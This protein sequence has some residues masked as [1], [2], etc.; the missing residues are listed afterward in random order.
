MTRLAVYRSSLLACFAAIAFLPAFSQSVVVTPTTVSFGN[1]PQG[2]SS[3][4]HKVTLKNGQSSA[5]TIS[6]ISTSLSDYIASNNCPVSPAT[7][8]AGATC[9]ISITFT[10][11]VE[12]SRTAALTVVDTGLSSPQLVTLNGTGTAP[13][14]LSIAVTPATA[15]VAAGY[16]EQFTATGTYSNGTTANLTNTAIWSSSAT[17]VAT[18]IGTSGLATG[19]AQGKASITATV[20]TI[21]GSTRLT[22]TPAVLTSLSVTPITAPIIAGQTQQFTATGTYS[23]GTS[24]NLTS[25]AK[26]SSSSTSVATVKNTGASHRNRSGHSYHHS[27]GR[28]CQRLSDIDRHVE[29][30]AFDFRHPRDGDHP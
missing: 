15:S 28:D 18:V 4:A 25:T 2:S 30:V 14:L 27:R 20:G 1:Q 23:N 21:N 13:S 6:S 16:T 11:S 24:Q 8:V 9:T 19:V 22:V 10:P 17:A 29:C 7:L 12:G 3:S 5:I 26:W